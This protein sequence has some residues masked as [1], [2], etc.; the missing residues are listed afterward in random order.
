MYNISMMNEWLRCP[1]L[2]YNRNVLRRE[3][4]ARRRPLPFEVGSLL[5]ESM[6]RKESLPSGTDWWEAL[7]SWGTVSIHARDAWRKHKLW[8]PIEAYEVPGWRTIGIEMRLAHSNLEGKL[9]RLVE[10]NG[11]FWSLQWKTFDEDLLLLNEKVRISH[12]EAA[13]QWL[14][15]Q[16]GYTP[17]GGTILGACQKL[18]GYRMIEDI[19]GK[20]HKEI[21]TDEQRINAF[22]THY[23]I[24]SPELQSRMIGDIRASLSLLDREMPIEGSDSVRRNYQEC[25][26]FSGRG[27]CQYFDVCHNGADINNDGEFATIQSRY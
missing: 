11:K 8:L 20:R 12:H 9:D 16:N 25:F 18:P 27:R 6:E 4:I 2:S 10:Y 15:E 3:H 24:R 26:G 14:A 17:F 7:P 19:H 21:V 23:L 1:Q 5:H 13:Y 22:T